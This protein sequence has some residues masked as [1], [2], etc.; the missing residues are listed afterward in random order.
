[1]FLA[2]LFAFSIYWHLPILIVIVS[3]VYS[4]TRSDDW[5][6]ILQEALSWGLR[7]TSFLV[8]IAI[9]LYIVATMT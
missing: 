1:V 2:P 3:L 8:G 6:K 7:L 9:V 4:A 5:M